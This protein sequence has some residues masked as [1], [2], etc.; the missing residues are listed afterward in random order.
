MTLARQVQSELIADVFKRANDDEFDLVHI[1][2]NEEE[3]ALPFAALCRKPVVFTHHD[4]F[5]FLVKYKNNFPKYK[6]LRWLSLSHAQRHGMP[7]DTNWIGNIY[8][9]LDAAGLAPVDAPTNDYIAYMGR[10]IEPKGVHLAIAAV[11]H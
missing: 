3:I 8:H 10:I 5:N 4:P 9:G 1:Y 2:T 7:K 11:Q 6:G